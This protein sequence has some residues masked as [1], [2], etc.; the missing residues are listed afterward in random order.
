[1]TSSRYF[2]VP[3]NALL[4][5]TAEVESSRPSA[6]AFGS[7]FEKDL[8]EWSSKSRVKKRAHARSHCA[9][10]CGCRTHSRPNTTGHS[11]TED[12]FN[13]DLR[14]LVRAHERPG[15]KAGWCDASFVNDQWSF[16]VQNRLVFFFVF[17][18]PSFNL[19]HSIVFN[20]VRSK[21][22]TQEHTAFELM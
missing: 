12:D 3:Q 4:T 17:L 15:E 22:V 2:F 16:A 14:A 1:M 19:V 21:F 13:N 9:R 18:V 11:F 20:W 8:Y 6:I 7:C 10:V 5:I